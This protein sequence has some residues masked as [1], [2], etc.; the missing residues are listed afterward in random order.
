MNELLTLA[1]ELLHLPDEPA[2]IP[3]A[4]WGVMGME[5]IASAFLKEI[6]SLRISVGAP[7]VVQEE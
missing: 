4:C 6:G 2:G 1:A 3:E 5:V 7:K